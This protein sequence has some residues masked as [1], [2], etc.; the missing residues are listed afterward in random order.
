VRSSNVFL[1][2]N[3]FQIVVSAR[4]KVKKKSELFRVTVEK[5]CAFMTTAFK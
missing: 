4:S 3:I 2:K 5:G 1:N